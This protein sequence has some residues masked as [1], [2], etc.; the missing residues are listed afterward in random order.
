MIRTVTIF[1]VILSILMA[2]DHSPVTNDSL[3]SSIDET[4]QNSPYPAADATSIVPYPNATRVNLLVGDLASKTR[5]LTDS[6][7]PDGV[8]LTDDQRVELAKTLRKV[9]VARKPME[10]EFKSAVGD[11]CFVPHHFFRFYNKEDDEIGEIAVC[12]CCADFR[13]HPELVKRKGNWLEEKIG[14]Q[15]AE[16]DVD[17]VKALVAEMG[18]PTNVGCD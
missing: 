2:C 9:T 6:S 10:D 18:M 12:F 8:D 13:A 14:D 17:K 1:A 11:A 16:M 7:N 5:K 15:W 4:E 3:K